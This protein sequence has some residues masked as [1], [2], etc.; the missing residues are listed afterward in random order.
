MVW[1]E[2]LNGLC[3]DA[4][5]DRRQIDSLAL[6]ETID[7][8][9]IDELLAAG[10]QQPRDGMSP[11]TEHGADGQGLCAFEEAIGCEGRASVIEERQES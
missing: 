3:A 11:E 10:C 4:G 8:R 9:P 1:F 5:L 6:E 7:R 2:Q